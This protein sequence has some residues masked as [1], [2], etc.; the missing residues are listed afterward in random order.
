VATTVPNFVRGATVLV[1]LAFN[2]LK[3]VKVGDGTVGVVASAAIVGVV[4]LLVAFWAA[5]G[6]QETY[7][8]DLD[9]IEPA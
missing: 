4:C 9:Y 7:D 3:T 6:L 1:T 8:K 2:H 5:S